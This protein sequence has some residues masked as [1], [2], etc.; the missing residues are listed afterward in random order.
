MLDDILFWSQVV[1]DSERTIVCSP[2]YESRLKAVIEARGLSGL[3]TV[4]AR[5][6]CPDDQMWVVDEHAADASLAQALARRPVPL[7]DF[8]SRAEQWRTHRYW[9]ARWGAAAPRVL[10]PHPPDLM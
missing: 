2:E 10:P 8:A 4:L 5:R 3:L 9:A 1:T 6:E 7:V